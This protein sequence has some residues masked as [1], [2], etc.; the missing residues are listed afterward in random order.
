MTVLDVSWTTAFRGV[1]GLI[2]K[3]WLVVTR[4]CNALANTLCC[5]S[6]VYI[7][8]DG[9]CSCDGQLGSSSTMLK[10]HVSRSACLVATNWISLLPSLCRTQC[11]IITK[12]TCQIQDSA[13]N[14]WLHVPVHHYTTTA[15]MHA[16][17][18]QACSISY[19]NWM[20]H[21]LPHLWRYRQQLQLICDHHRPPRHKSVSKKLCCPR[22]SRNGAWPW[23]RPGPLGEKSL[24]VSTLRR[25]FCSLTV[26]TTSGTTPGNGSVEVLLWVLWRRALISIWNWDYKNKGKLHSLGPYFPKW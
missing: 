9:L 26:C 15:Q 11:R 2:G 1:L 10:V 22:P 16:E 5:I 21:E 12:S 20:L 24:H 6:G 3:A 23:G 17:S 13:V 4:V 19:W 18:S 8:T 25:R 14:W 7:Q